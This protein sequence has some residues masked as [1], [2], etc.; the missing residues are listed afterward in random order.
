MLN[1]R[2][3][4]FLESKNRLPKF[5][6]GFRQSRSTIDNIIALE[7]RIRKGWS[8]RKKTFAVFLDMK[9][10][11]DSV[12]IPGLLK[13]LAKLGITGLMLFWLKNF[14]I[15]RSFR[16][17]VGSTLSESRPLFA[18]VP[19]G[20]ILSPLL[21]NIMLIDF[22]RP[23]RNI[24]TLLYADDI[25]VDVAADS[26]IEAKRQLQPFLRKIGEWAVKWK[27]EFAIE[28]SVL[29]TFSRDAASHPPSLK[30]MGR[31]IPAAD[32]TKF[33]G[34]HLDRKLIWK[35]HINKVIEK[36]IK[37]NNIFAVLAKRRFGPS[38]QTLV[39]LYKT[40]IRSQADYGLIVYGVAAKT[41][42]DKLDAALRISL[43]TILG[44]PKST[45]TEILYSELGLEPTPT[46]RKW[47]AA[48]YALRLGR[49]PLNIA[50]ESAYVAA[51]GPSTLTPSHTQCLSSII[52]RV[53]SIDRQAFALQPD[54]RP[55]FFS[56]P[57]WQ[58]PLVN[59]LW[60]A[61]SKKM[62]LENPSRARQV[63][64]D[65]IDGLPGDSIQVYTDGSHQEER[66]ATACA[67]YIPSLASEK[68]FLLHKGASIFTAEISAILRALR[69]LSSL[70]SVKPGQEIFIFVD[71][72]AAIRAI[73]SPAVE[74]EDLVLHTIEAIRGL[75]SAGCKI[76][77]VWIPS[78]IGVI[79]NER[80]DELAVAGC[81]SLSNRASDSFLSVAEAVSLFKKSWMD[82]RREILHGYGKPVTQFHKSPSITPWLFCKNRSVSMALHRLRSGHN[83]L[84]AFKHRIDEA[85]DP[86]CRYQ[87]EALE[88]AEHLL[89]HCLQF[90]DLRKKLV[91]FCQDKK[92]PFNLL[93][94][95]G[96]NSDIDRSTQ[97]RLSGLLSRFIIQANIVELI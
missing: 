57:P 84:N 21:F 71:S 59:V 72:Q 45:P 74:K 85:A 3:T 8:E 24:Q 16:V 67:F 5:Q 61:N 53:R 32:S 52:Q 86:S 87:C 34:M 39:L 41:H 73:V 37:A 25:E 91:T 11:F 90:V 75:K 76:T 69:H 2:L 92:I 78:H 14:L 30:L 68:T 65:F 43:R 44:A 82:E 9:K 96:L 81:A 88:N 49:K 79:G 55:S 95:L 20:S 7:Q 94:V 48:R 66:D 56:P 6:S 17:R 58:P 60:F 46:R 38:I 77:L 83:R 10:A 31:L 54:S 40:L 19:Q 29:V 64:Q 93:T 1:T 26:G 12:W 63:I 80:A 28:K 50:Y 27:F 62:A 36:I 35:E 47:L 33:L 13:K 70:D 51:S 15:G 97:F 89:L 22:P 23:C 4:W 18:G 42:M